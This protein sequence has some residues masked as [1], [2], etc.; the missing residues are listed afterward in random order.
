MMRYQDNKKTVLLVGV[1]LLIS[2]A[3]TAWKLSTLPTQQTE[4]LHSINY[5]CCLALQILGLIVAVILCITYKPKTWEISDIYDAWKLIKSFDHK[6]I[7]IAGFVISI[8]MIRSSITFGTQED[9][10]VDSDEESLIGLS[11]S[12]S[13]RNRSTTPTYKIIS[14]K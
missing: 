3:A 12:I 2:S 4:D 8:A 6:I 11:E 13:T 1:V 10:S 14:E 7:I 9:P 5:I